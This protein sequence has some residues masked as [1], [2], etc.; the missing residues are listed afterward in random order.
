MRSTGSKKLSVIA[1]LLPALFAAGS[2]LA[3][4]PVV[5]RWK[6]IDGDTGK[7]KSI[8]EITQ[9]P[10][11]TITGRIVE[12]LNPSKPNPV[13]DKCKDDRKNQPI[14]GMEII[15]GMKAEGGGQYSG[16][17]ILKPDEGKVYKS[18]MELVEGGKKLEVSGCVAF[19]CKSQTWLRQ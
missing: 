15:R 5:G 9:A 13:C 12:L 6:T 4:D 8:V 18:K 11:G 1:L 7:P 14:T 2:A 19:I 3:A 10:N 16:G 17:T